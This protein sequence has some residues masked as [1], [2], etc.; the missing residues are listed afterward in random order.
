[1]IRHP[2]ERTVAFNAIEPAPVST[3]SKTAPGATAAKTQQPVLAE[4]TDFRRYL[5]DVYD[6]RRETEST[7]LR[8]YSYSTFSAAADIKSP[9]YLKLIIEGRRNLSEDMITRFAKALR[10]NRAETEEFRAL[11]RYGQATEPIERNQFLKELADLRAR[12][13]FEAGQIN[14]ASWEKVPGWIGWVLYAMAEQRGVDFRPEEVQ[15]LFRAK[16]SAEDIREA[17]EKLIASGELARNAETG[18]V[19]KGRDLV[20]SPQNLPVE[21]IRKLQAEL[22]YLGIES[23]FRDSPKEREFGA[24]T[25]AMT[26]EEFNQVRFELR[27]LRKR[28]QKDILVKRKSTKGERV[29]QL[30][31]QLFPVTDKA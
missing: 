13:A 30:N 25:V 8:A 15:R 24:M 18:E 31:V 20:E 27:Q 4:Y 23:L 2:G 9:N 6:Y 19:G 21:L 1:M 28:L 16:A 17:M 26:E 29:Y 10:L 12:R 14:Q 5:K 22:I 11:T 3:Q 7:G